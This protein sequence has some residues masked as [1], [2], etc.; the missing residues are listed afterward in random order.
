MDR[1]QYYVQLEKD[2][3]KF[4]ASIP[5]AIVF[6]IILGCILGFFHYSMETEINI[7]NNGLK[8]QGSNAI[9][10]IQ[11]VSNTEPLNLQVETYDIKENEECY[12]FYYQLENN[13]QQHVEV[14]DK[15]DIKLLN[16]YGSD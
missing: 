13:P 15:E 3:Q 4:Y 12:T 1:Q 16:I 7:E 5:F 6:T 10:T 14:I 9:I 2:R 8:M 11:Y